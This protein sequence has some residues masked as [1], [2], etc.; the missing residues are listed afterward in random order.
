MAADNAGGSAARVPARNV[1]ILLC[2]A[3]GLAGG[4]V[5]GTIAGWLRQQSVPATDIDLPSIALLNNRVDALHARVDRQEGIAADAGVSEPGDTGLP[6]DLFLRIQILEERMTA[7]ESSLARSSPN[8]SSSD[9]VTSNRL[10][11]ELDAAKR[12]VEN[13][14]GSVIRNE[15]RNAQNDA[16]TTVSRDDPASDIRKLQADL[17]RLSLRL[18]DAE[19]EIDRWSRQSR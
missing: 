9:L 1:S 5:G 17:Y 15:L 4:L 8:L 13:R 10:M 3:V 12:E 14:M 6:D 11:R 2:L 18:T 16:R 19:R 7:A